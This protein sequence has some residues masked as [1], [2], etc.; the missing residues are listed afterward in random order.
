M[1]TEADHSRILRQE[2]YL[3]ALFNKDLLDLRVRIPVHQTLQ[4]WLPPRLLAGPPQTGL[5]R[6]GEEEPQYLSFGGNVLTQALEWNLRWCL[7]GFLFD[8]NGQVRKEVVRDKSRNLVTQLQTRFVFAGLLNAVFAPFIVVYLLLYS[9]F[10]YFEVGGAS[11][12]TDAAGVPQESI[13]HGWQAVHSLRP[14][15]VPRVQRAASSL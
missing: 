3:I 2:N 1:G 5:P 4:R 13:F 10:R 9:F 6:T 7:M 15:E 14:V 8:S 11:D 12:Q